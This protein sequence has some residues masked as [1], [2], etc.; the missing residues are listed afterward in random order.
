MSFSVYRRTLVLCV[1]VSGY[2]LKFCDKGTDVILAFQWRYEYKTFSILC[3]SCTCMYGRS[4]VQEE[5]GDLKQEV[6]LNRERLLRKELWTWTYLW[7]RRA[8]IFP[9]NI[10]PEKPNREAT[11]TKRSFD[12]SHKSETSGNP[13]QYIHTFIFAGCLY[14]IK[15]ML[16]TSRNAKQTP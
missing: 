13:K 9:W 1:T 12:W 15:C 14:Q 6:Q 11:S 7:R 16:W 3:T 4:I 2:L 8:A 10:I 5:W